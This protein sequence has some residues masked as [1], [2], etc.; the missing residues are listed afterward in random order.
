MTMIV[1][2]H[3]IGFAREVARPRRLHGRRRHRRAGRARRALQQ[4]AALPDQDIS[5]EGAVNDMTSNPARGPVDATMTPRYAGPATF[6]RLPRIDEVA[7]ADVAILG[8]PFDSGVSYR[9]GARFGPAHIRALLQAA[10]A[11]QPG[12]GRRSP[13]A[14]AAGRRRRRH[15]RQPVRHRRGRPAD[16]RAAHATSPATGAKLLTIGGD[17]TIALPL[18]RVAARDARPD[19][20]AALRRP[21]RH[22]GHL[23]RR[24]VHP[25]H[26]VPPGRRGGAAR[27]GTLPC[28]WASAARSTPQGPRAT[29]QALGF[30][31]VRR[32]RHATTDR[33]RRAP[34]SG[35]GAGWA[36]GPVYVS[37][38][39]D[40][41]DPALAPGTGTPEAGGLTSRELLNILRGLAGL[42]L[43]GADIVE[44]APAYD[45]AEITGIA[46]VARRLRAA[47]RAGH[48]RGPGMTPHR[49]DLR[50]A[51]QR[52]RRRRRVAGGQRRR[53]PSSA[54]PAPTTSSCTGTCRT[55]GIRHV[56]TRHEQGAGY[57]ADGY[58]QVSGR[59]G[60]VHHHQRPGDHQ[61][62]RPRSRT[63]YADS[64]PAADHLARAPR[65]ARSA[66]TPGRLHEVKDQQGGARLPSATAA[67]ASRART[68]SPTRW[69]TSSRASPAVARGRCTSRCRSTS[70]RGSGC[71]GRC[72]PALLAARS[73][74]GPR[75]SLR[76][77]QRSPAARRPLLVAGGG[78]RAAA[79]EV[80]ALA[81]LGIPVLTTVNGKGVLD[82]RH[83]SALGASVRLAAAHDAG[84]PRRRAA[85][86]RDRGW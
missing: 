7:R 50:P 12:A 27:P 85:A 19:R 68:T 43:V 41:L 9:P 24:A 3:E 51:P 38:D 22:L 33:R 29:T 84:E 8:V 28:T 31:I 25:R 61:R 49:D 74:P 37:I 52:R 78:A 15:R 6:A 45:H 75:R 13:F 2:T 69:R 57:A 26:A 81:D 21:P 10:A 70:S 17:H 76:S 53:R 18:L 86:G 20:G 80:R 46:A 79:A 73:V 54:S 63:A 62:R 72:G 40:V 71:A 16:R 36:T 48:G 34:S 58:D 5:L 35:C 30:Q 1:V 11:V 66:A 39:I 83:P 64:V 4:P 23:L 14:R 59:P 60:V 42:N 44:V 77:Q 65:G 32:R 56:T 55:S 82:E 67:S 47:V